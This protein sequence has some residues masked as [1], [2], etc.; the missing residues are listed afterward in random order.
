MLH[1]QLPARDLVA[2]QVHRFDARADELDVARA[3]D[4]GEVGV[5]GEE[6]IAGV[7]RVHVRHLGGADDAR[8]VEVAFGRRGRADADAAIGQAHVRRLPVRRG[9]DRH[10]LHVQLA[11]RPDDPD[12]HLAVTVIFL[13]SQFFPF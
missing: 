6:A 5:L 8:D 1:R 12:G 9:K 13:Y 10:R 4:L 11:R 3:A 7:D 2:Q